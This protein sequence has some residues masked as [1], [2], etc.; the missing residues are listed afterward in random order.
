MRR[1]KP[2]HND[3]QPSEGQA[4]AVQHMLTSYIVALWADPGAGKTSI[5][6]AAFV[7]LQGAG[8]VATMLVV[9]PLRVCQLVWRQEAQKWTQFRHLRVVLL[10]GPKKD[11]ILKAG[12]A[13]SADVF[14]INYEG[15]D[16]LCDKYYR[17]N[18]PF[19]VVC[20]DEITKLK[21]HDSK[22]AKKLRATT[23]R[24]PHKWGLTGTPVP[25]GYMDLFGQFLWLDGGA[26]LGKFITHYRDLYFKSDFTGW[27]YELQA[28]AAERIEE[29]IA[30]Y[31]FRL[32]YGAMPMVPDIRMLEMSKTDRARYREMKK[33]MLIELPEGTVTA[34]NAAAVQQKLSQMAN[35]AVYYVDEAG[36]RRWAPLH[37]TKLDALDELMEELAGKQLMIAYEFGHDIERI[38]ARF[39]GVKV[40]RGSEAEI[41][42]I[43]D[44]WNTGKLM[45]MA[46]HP[47]SV[48]HGV[49]AQLSSAMHIAWFSATWNLEHWDQLIRRLRRQGSKAEF[50]VNHV[51][52]VEGTIDELKLEAL[53]G[54]DVTQ[55][56]LLQGLRYELSEDTDGPAIR[57]SATARQVGE[58]AGAPRGIRNSHAREDQR[59]ADVGEERRGRD[60]PRAPAGSHDA[61]PE[62]DAGAA[63]QSPRASEEGHSDR[64]PQN[65]GRAEP[66]PGRT[67]TQRGE[68]TMAG[69]RLP[70]KN[71]AP[72]A[73]E[74]PVARPAV[75]GWPTKAAAPTAPAAAPAPVAPQREAIRARVAAPVVQP[76]LHEDATQ[77]NYEERGGGVDAPVNARG[78]FS[79]AVQTALAGETGAGVSEEEAQRLDANN[80]TR[81]LEPPI[82]PRAPRQRKED[83]VADAVADVKGVDQVN[84]AGAASNGVAINLSGLPAAAIKAALEAIAANL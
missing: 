38:Q 29:R 18:L 70:T 7:A 36:D 76:P 80:Q 19:D 37:D 50:I 4:A 11:E 47:A 65:P 14:L 59:G 54:K 1:V 68:L 26:A 64:L 55:A 41:Q 49:N 43:L 53:D 79:P 45:H 40:L 21:A 61:G 75:K 42:A 63:P 66:V 51:F 77:Q 22:R 31:V 69:F 74:A 12:L 32:A 13:G 39:P 62:S 81:P 20:A 25:N 44:E 16:W 56:R 84:Y 73:E 28:G 2:S 34:A 24:T 71:A 57:S 27:N 52:A 35:G 23:H 48:G 17:Q 78:M 82:K 10:H 8:V 67:P 60:I 58:G 30:P 83:K 72:A 3:W 5:T 15:L 33:E 46:V 6:L 9:A